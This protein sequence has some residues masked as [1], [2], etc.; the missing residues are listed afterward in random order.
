MAKATLSVPRRSLLR[1]AAAGVFAISMATGLAAC[2][3]SDAATSASKAPTSIKGQTVRVWFMEGSVSEPAIKKLTDSFAAKYPGNTLKVEIQPWD[4]IV[5][6]IQTSL[7]SKTESPDL[8][9]TGNTQSSTFSTVGAFADATDLKAG[10]GGDDLIKS[11]VDAGTVDG[12]IYAYPLYAGARGV[13]YRKDL[14]EKAGIAVP[15]TIA[16]FNAAVIKLG[17]TNPGKYPGFS[18]MYLSAVDIHGVESYLFPQGFE[19]ATKDG[20]KWVG[21][22]TTP[23]SI[24]ALTNLQELFKKGTSFALDSA[25]GQKKFQDNFN[26]DKVGVLIGTGNVGTKIDKAKWDAGQVGVIALPGETAGTPGT[27]FAGGSSISI[28]RNAKNPELAR[29]ALKLIF[30]EDFQ[31]QIAADGWAPGNNKYGDKVAGAFGE[32]SQ[33]VIASSKLT[34]NTPQWGVANGKGL[35]KDLFTKVAQGGDVAAIAEEYNARIESELNAS[36]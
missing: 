3:G 6:K 12:K 29:E 34:P 22:L 35:T 18:G 27:V 13:F 30:A 36:K 26:T 1:G 16:E 24:A 20:D 11:F 19:F 28:A 2:G 5:A 9:E 23:E 32:I 8:V 10:L 14:F 31:L 15:N 21:K 25:A 4:G 17:A 7:S 33:K